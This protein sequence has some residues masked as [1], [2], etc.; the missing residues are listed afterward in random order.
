MINRF[1]IS[2]QNDGKFLIG[3]DYTMGNWSKLTIAGTNK[4]A[5]E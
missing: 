5:C 3:A 4:A 2:Y 1:G